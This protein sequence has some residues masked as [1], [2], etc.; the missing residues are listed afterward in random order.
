MKAVNKRARR[1]ERKADRRLAEA[2]DAGD[3]AL[4]HRARKAA[5]RARYAAELRTP[6]EKQAKK[7]AKHYKQFQRVLGDH[8]D[9]VVATATLQRLA[10]TAGTTPGENGFTYRL[11]YAREELA[12]EAARRRAKEL[13]G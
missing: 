2:I 11:L 7:T 4:L 10:I 8:Q 5:K 1:A 6:V 12:A 3:D 13:V 9:S